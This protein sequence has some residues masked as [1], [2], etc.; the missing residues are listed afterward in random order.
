[1]AKAHTKPVLECQEQR[2]IQSLFKMVGRKAHKQLFYNGK[3]KDQRMTG[4]KIHTK[5][6]LEQWNCRRYGFV[7]SLVQRTLIYNLFQQ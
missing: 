1:M 5:A 7:W 2:P 3:C 6:L 4:K